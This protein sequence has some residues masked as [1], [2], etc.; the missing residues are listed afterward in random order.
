M[1]ASEDYFNAQEWID[2]I[3]GINS[4][5]HTARVRGRDGNP[6]PPFSSSDE[7]MRATEKHIRFDNDPPRDS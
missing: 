5:A 3:K 4:D 6:H 2:G 1:K 7:V